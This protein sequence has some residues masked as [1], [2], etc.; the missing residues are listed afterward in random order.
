MQTEEATEYARNKGMVYI[1]TSAKT[2]VGIQ[3]AFE[4]LVQK[5]SSSSLPSPSLPSSST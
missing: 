2:K 5:V 3:Q 1:E 4:E